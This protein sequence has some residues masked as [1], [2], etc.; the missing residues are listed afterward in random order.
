MAH[1]TSTTGHTAGEIVAVAASERGALPGFESRCECGLRIANTVR[2]NVEQDIR[3]HAAYFGLHAF[4][5]NPARR[6]AVCTVCRLGRSAHGRGV[7]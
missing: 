5:R 4:T 1:S 6:E 7:R 2:S 3:E